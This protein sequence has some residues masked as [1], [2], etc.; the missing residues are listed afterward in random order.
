M[1][2]ASRLLALQR[3]AYAAEAALI[4][5]DRIPGLH[6]TL[7]ELRGADLTWLAVLDDRGAPLA[8][9]AARQTG[10]LIDIDRLVVAPSAARQGY[11]SHLVATVLAQA[12]GAGYEVV[13]ATGR[14]NLPAR[15]LY[16]QLGFR[17]TGDEEPVPGLW[18]ASYR[19]QHRARAR[20]LCLDADGK[21][22]LL[23]WQDRRTGLPVHEPPGGGVEP[24]EN[25]LAAARRE[26]AEQT[27]LP[28]DVVLDQAPLDV[29]R[30]YRRNGRRHVARERFFLAR[31]RQRAPQVTPLSLA[32]AEQAS[33]RGHVWWRAGA[34]DRELHVEPAGLADVLTALLEAET[35][36]S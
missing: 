26:L 10:R 16:E 35:S 18:V 6:E 15:R 32:E 36:Q 17:H 21:V 12:A 14:D 11:G 23:A 9:L 31:L 5:D 1:V 28:G 33:Y 8:A 4:R 2:V 29:V 25:G 13:V 22:L 24:G 30:D 19:W 27:G 20:V 3:E 7:E 34:D